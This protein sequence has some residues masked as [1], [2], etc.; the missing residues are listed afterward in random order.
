MIKID[1]RRV[2]ATSSKSIG[3]YIRISANGQIA[4]SGD[5]VRELGIKEDDKAVFFQDNNNPKH[6]YFAFGKEGDYLIKRTGKKNVD[7][8]AFSSSGLRDLFLQ[9]LDLPKKTVR[10]WLAKEPVEVEGK[11]LWLL[12]YR[13]R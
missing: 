2:V 5:T 4:I 12:N 11:K 3:Q 7:T 9:S 1:L 6:W 13:D 10:L 8:M